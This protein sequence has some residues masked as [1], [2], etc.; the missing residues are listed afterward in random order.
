MSSIAPPNPYFSGIN[1]NPAFFRS[2]YDYLTETIANTLYLKLRGGS[3]SGNLGIK[4]SP[5]N[6][7]LEVNGKIDIG[8]TLGLPFNGVYGANGTKLILE[9]G[10]AS[11]TPSAIG[12][13]TNNLWFGS[14]TLGFLSF[15]IGVSGKMQIKNNGYVGIGT[16]DVQNILQIGA[17]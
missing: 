6:V 17:G 1:F 16:T 12:A 13:N 11:S 9:E 5:A 14:S 15:Y 3:L 4:K 8:R 2:I 10:T 7:E